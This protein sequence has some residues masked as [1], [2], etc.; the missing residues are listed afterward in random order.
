MKIFFCILAFL[1]AIIFIET[2]V[3]YVLS[4]DNFIVMFC[5]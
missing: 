1:K 3:N 5:F 2:C 4:V